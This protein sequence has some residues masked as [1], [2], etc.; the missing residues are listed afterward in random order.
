MGH[1]A[2]IDLP[3]SPREPREPKRAKGGTKN[4]AGAKQVVMQSPSW[5]QKGPE[6][7]RAGAKE[8]PG[9]PPIRA[10]RAR[11]AP[12]P[13]ILILA[14][15]QGWKQ[16]SG[17]FH[18]PWIL[19]LQFFLRN[20]K[21]QGCHQ[22]HNHASTRV[23][24]KEITSAVNFI[25]ISYYLFYISTLISFPSNSRRAKWDAWCNVPRKEAAARSATNVRILF[26]RR[27]KTE[28][29]S[30]SLRVLRSHASCKGVLRSSGC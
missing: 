16:R 13:E 12:E 18:Q 29:S 7:R 2:Q 25:F 5:S 23:P 6:P 26:S 22:H 20:I 24:R 19:F 14:D 27:R 1:P 30:Y 17:K 11:A 4:R 9:T 28:L 3:Q 8:E 21:L 15:F 10:K